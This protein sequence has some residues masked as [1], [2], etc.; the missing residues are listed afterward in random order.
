MLNIANEPGIYSGVSRAS[1]DAWYGPWQNDGDFLDH[2]FVNTN[3]SISDP[4]SKSYIPKGFK[5]SIL[6]N[7]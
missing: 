6:Q 3:G 1:L 2:V 4:T 5:Y 7:G